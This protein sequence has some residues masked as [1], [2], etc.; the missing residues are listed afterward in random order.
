VR[1]ASVPF[2]PAAHDPT[3]FDCG[4]PLLNSWLGAHAEAE[5]KRGTA[6][7]W[8]WLDDDGQIVGYYSLS[9]SKVRRD[10]VPSALGRGGPEEIPAVLLGRLALHLSLH[11]R[12]LDELLVADA[13]GR[14]VEATRTVGARVVVVDALHEGAAVF[15]ER[16]GFRRIP[17]GLLLVQ[18]VA[19][20]R[21][22]HDAT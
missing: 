11:G 1:F 5:I 20:I 7:V 21:V 15:Y 3:N 14:I 10:E 12:N 17:N 9:A 13:L 8:V 4:E 18:K 2:D 19:D 16:L 22:A 6:R